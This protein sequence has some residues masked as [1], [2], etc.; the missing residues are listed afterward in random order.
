MKRFKDC[1]LA[2]M[3]DGHYCIIRDLGPVKGG[4]GL[5]HHEVIVDFTW[6]ALTK[7]LTFTQRRKLVGKS[8][9]DKWNAAAGK[10]RSDI[11]K[12]PKD[13]FAKKRHQRSAQP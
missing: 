4:N 8:E 11:G 10:R 9:S 2:R 1:H 5:K 13:K 6:R 7:F 12:Q 3:S